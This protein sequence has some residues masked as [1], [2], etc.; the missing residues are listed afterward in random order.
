LRLACA[1]LALACGCGT[2]RALKEAVEATKDVAI[3]AKETAI[4]LK[5]DAES[6]RRATDV[7]ASWLEYASPYVLAAL[8]IGA[9][10]LL[11]WLW[12]KRWLR[13]RA[14]RVEKP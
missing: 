3:A 9:P 1:L 10:L 4:A 6:R 14:A 7:L 11:G 13:K 12:R 2:I 5:Q 8:A